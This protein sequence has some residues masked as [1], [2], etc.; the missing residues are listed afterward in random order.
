MNRANRLV[1]LD[2]LLIEVATQFALAH[3]DALDEVIDEGLGRIAQ[4]LNLDR[5]FLLQ[6]ELRSLPFVESKLQTGEPLCF[7][8]VDE[9]PGE[10]NRE[11]LLRYGLRSAAIVPVPTPAAVAGPYALAFGSQMETEWAPA[12]PRLQLL[13]GVVGQALARASASKALRRVISEPREVSEDRLT[14]PAINATGTPSRM[15]SKCRAVRQ[16]FEHVE[17]VASLPSTVLLLGETGVGKEVFAEE[18]HA[19]SPRRE[20]EMI[21]V[22]CS[23]IPSALIESELFG[24]ERGAYTGAHT[25]QIGRFEAANH[26]TLF[27]DEIGELSPELQVKLL[28]VLDSRVIERL[29]SSQSI[30]VDIRIIAATNRD[31]EHAVSAGEFR[32]DLF[33]RLNV[34]P[35]RLP[36]LRQRVED[37]P[38]LAWQFIEE[39]SK[40]Y[41]KNIDTISRR[42]MDELCRHPWPGNIRELR[43]V[44]ERSVIH[45]T[46]DTL[47]LS[48]RD[49]VRPHLAHDTTAASHLRIVER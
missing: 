46:G 36:A 2:R 29:G 44:I 22:N 14:R 34:F 24:R 27:L 43:N 33:Y 15:A 26:S 10:A 41:G 30:K 12:L 47:S 4:T 8:L 6:Q 17:R 11:A 28:R 49:D 45:T 3:R 9:V 18:I 23:A 32:E 37:I 21:R 35:I 25:R 1:D 38:G 39:F 13:S 5:V 19:R 40:K 42:S 20:R 7:T 48:I 16:A 31:L